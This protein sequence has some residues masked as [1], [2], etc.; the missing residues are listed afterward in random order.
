MWKD[1]TDGYDDAKQGFSCITRIAPKYALP[2]SVLNTD[3]SV[4]QHVA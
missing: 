4:L 1:G 2:S 3:S